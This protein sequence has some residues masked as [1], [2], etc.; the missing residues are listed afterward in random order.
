MASKQ[1]VSDGW[2]YKNWWND[3]KDTPYSWQIE[4]STTGVSKPL[5]MQFTMIGAVTNATGKTPCHWKAMWSVNEIDWMDI[6][7][8]YVPD[9]IVNAEPT[10]WQLPGMKQFDIPLPTQMLDKAKVYLRLLPASKITNTT[11]YQGGVIANGDDSGN[12]MDY[13]AIRYN[14]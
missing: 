13:F 2:F 14:K 6:A 9:G 1:A 5:S 3:V 7:E 12:G 8:F 4:F 11:L 10:E